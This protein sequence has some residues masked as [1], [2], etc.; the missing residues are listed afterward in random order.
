MNASL[1]VIIRCT[2][3]GTPPLHSS[4]LFTIK[5]E[6]VNETPTKIIMQGGMYPEN[7]RAGVVATFSTVD[8]DD[9]TEQR[10]VGT[11]ILVYYLNTQYD[12][13]LL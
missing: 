12:N 9:E 6:D 5:V 13:C 11:G 7:R 4:R 3:T 2:D 10:E 8:P 1:S